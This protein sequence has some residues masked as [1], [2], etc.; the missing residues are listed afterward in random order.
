[1]P[2]K[3]HPGSRG[4]IVGH[5]H[6]NMSLLQKLLQ[7]NWGLVLL[8]LTLSG[9]GLGMLY[10]A[11]NGNFDPWASRQAVRLAG[12]C[13]IMLVVALVDIRFWFKC[14]Y[15]FYFG[16]L[17]LLI[18]VEV[19][20]SVGMG[21]KRWINLGVIQLQPSELMKIAIVM[22]LARYF[23]GVSAENIRRPLMLIV[24]LLMVAAPSV[25]VLKQPDLGTTVLLIMASGAVFFC[26]GVRLWKFVLVAVAGMAAIPVGWQFLK[27]YQQNRVL[28]FLD[29]EKDP[30]GTGYN[31]IQSKIALG[32]G[33]VSGKGFLQGTQSHLNFLP[34]KQTDFIF[35]MLAEEFGMIGA[36]A[37]LG[38]YILVLIYGMAISARARNQYARLLALGLTTNLFLYVFINMAMVMGLVPVVGVPLPLISYGGTVMLTILIGIGLVMSAW[39]HRD[40][41]IPRHGVV[42]GA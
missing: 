33:G 27:P 31:I 7:I 12:G 15:L 9:I 38:I 3:V 5:K 8:V 4:A 25:L 2:V 13:I 6:E 18:G 34:E 19:M 41:R 21:A 10:S 14:S 40:I 29:P 24:P 1:M 42:E 36:L 20:G 23:H 11:A 37:L 35:T 39:V 22:A 16:A 28:T 32:S 30:L 26:A 17:I